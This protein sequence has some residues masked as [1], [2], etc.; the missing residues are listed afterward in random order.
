MNYRRW[1]L[2]LEDVAVR[3]LCKYEM[4]FSRWSLNQL[5]MG[6]GTGVL[7]ALFLPF[8]IYFIVSIL[9]L[10]E[11][12]L[13]VHGLNLA[14]LTAGQVIDS[15]L[16][17]DKISLLNTLEKIALTDKN[18]TYVFIED[19]RG[20]IISHTFKN[21]FPQNLL[22]FLKNNRNPVVKFRTNDGPVL[23]AS[24][25][26]MS[27][28]LG[29]LHIGFSRNQVIESSNRLLIILSIGITGALILIFAGAWF[30][31]VKVS[32]PLRILEKEVSRFTPEKIPEKML[33][34]KGTREVESLAH[35]F[36]EMAHRLN[37]LEHEREITQVKMIHAERLSALGEM[38]AGLTHEIRNPLDGM[39]ECVRYLESDTLKSERQAKFLPMIHDGLQRINTVIQNMLMFSRS[40]DIT[41]AEIC[42]TADIINEL[43]IMLQA[44]IKSQKI[45]LTWHKPGTCKCLCNKQALVQT[46]LNLVLNAAEALKEKES[47]EILIE[48]KCDSLWVYISVDDNGNGVQPGLEDKIFEPFYTT[49]PPGKG[50]GLGLPISRQLIRAAGGDLILSP[51][52]SPLGGARFEIKIPRV[53]QKES[54]NV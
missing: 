22:K 27:G 46:L 53:Y 15:E 47:P 8:C 43:E 10:N 50:T 18:I 32:K 20:E 26:I 38:A 29:F 16:V 14:E 49:K 9:Q 17:G 5:L 30:V 3:I 36:N 37:I 52:P 33:E 1:S 13:E 12:N 24:A 25:S 54:C 40:G 7:F 2:N 31:S 39:L 23:D 45:L 28:Q 35:G 41:T 21:G 11:R 44:K 42:P 19:A 4:N 51:Q 34:L 48:A 6:L